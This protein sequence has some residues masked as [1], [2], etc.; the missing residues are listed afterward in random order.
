LMG[1]Q[2]IHDDP[3]RETRAYE[4]EQQDF[5]ADTE[6]PL[7]HFL[8]HVR[9]GRNGLSSREADRRVLVFGANKLRKRVQRTWPRDLARQ[10]T[11]PRRTRRVTRVTRPRR[12]NRHGLLGVLGPREEISNEERLRPQ[13]ALPLPT[14][15][16]PYRCAAHTPSGEDNS[17]HGH[18][19]QGRQI[20]AVCSPRNSPTL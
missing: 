9:A 4:V 14:Q 20:V 19:V 2:T 12:R 18:R 7:A 13:C 3:T 6:E 16:A 1:A 10:F 5:S 11:H 15:L 17:A 8:R